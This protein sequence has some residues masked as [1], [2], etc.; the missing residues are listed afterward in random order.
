MT[1]TPAARGIGRRILELQRE[2]TERWDEAADRYTNDLTRLVDGEIGALEFGKDMFNLAVTETVSAVE[3][4][5]RL[6]ADYY[7]WLGGRLGIRLGGRED[8]PDANKP[9]SADAR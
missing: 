7:H 2:A 1:T 8:A 3:G 5:A 6:G 9:T 4:A